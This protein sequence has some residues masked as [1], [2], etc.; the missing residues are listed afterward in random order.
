MPFGCSKSE[1]PIDSEAMAGEPKTVLYADLEDGDVLVSV[2]GRQ[3]TKAEVERRVALNVALLKY[4]GVLPAAQINALKGRLARQARDKFVAQAMLTGVAEREKVEANEQTLAIAWGEVAESYGQGGASNRIES[5]LQHLTP[6][7]RKQL[8]DDVRAGARIYAC[9][10]RL[11]G[12]KVKVTEAEID[13]VAKRG[14]EMKQRS[15]KV[16]TEQ[17]LKALSL[18]ARLQKGEDFSVVAAAS[19]TADED[20][21]IGLWGEFSL[22]ELEQLIPRLGPAVAKLGVGDYTSPIE[23]DDAIYIIR[24]KAREG[25]GEPSSVNLAPERRTLERIVVN[26]PVMY[27]V[28]TREQIRAGILDEKRTEY[29]RN[30]LMPELQ[31]KVAITYPNGKIQFAKG[32]KQ[33]GRKQ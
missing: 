15:I 32:T 28:G 18:F 31:K 16:L 33:K 12:D 5:I 30:V 1:N 6:A 8:E 2:D 10:D 3:L 11:A 25:S 22:G 24:L 21:G 29:Q 17:R 4:K 19:D 20:E 26:L 9:I 14:A 27:E 13:D 7:L 23:C